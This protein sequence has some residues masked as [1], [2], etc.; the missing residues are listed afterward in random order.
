MGRIPAFSFASIPW[1]TFVPGETSIQAFAVFLLT[2]DS[3][4]RI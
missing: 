1:T 2:S 4:S 3:V